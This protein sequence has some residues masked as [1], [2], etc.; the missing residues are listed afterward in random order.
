MAK[1]KKKRDR[2]SRG[3]QPRRKEASKTKK[4]Q[5]K[6][7]KRRSL[8]TQLRPVRGG[9][10]KKRKMRKTRRWLQIEG[11]KAAPAR[12][13]RGKPGTRQAY[14]GQRL[15][16]TSGEIK[17]PARACPLKQ[18]HNREGTINN[19][20]Q[21]REIGDTLKGN[22]GRKKRTR[23]GTA[24]GPHWHRKGEKGIPWPAPAFY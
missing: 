22:C 18:G 8:C 14:P 5:V 7:E 9:K 1:R 17:E 10:P 23:S 20:L 19:E 2:R 6:N 12:D 4:G 11:K 24:S 21:K 13:E 16:R 15:P 3:V